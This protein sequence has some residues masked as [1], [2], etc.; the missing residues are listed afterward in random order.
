[1][2]TSKNKPLRFGLYGENDVLLPDFLHCEIMPYRS[3]MNNWVIKPH[4]HANL[5][6]LFLIEKAHI[7]Y[8]L[9]DGLHF[10]PAP[11][12]VSIPENNDH[13]LIVSPGI[14]GMVLTLSSS[15]VETIF[16]AAPA[17]LIELSK[18]H[19]FVKLRDHKFYAAIRRDMYALYDEIQEVLPQRR[20]I[21]QAQLALLLS[22]IFRLS[23]E[24]S[25]HTVAPKSIYTR[26]FNLFLRD[27]KKSST[28]MK[29]VREYADA[30]NITAVHLN[31]IC[32]A[33]VGKSPLD[34]IHEFLFLEAGK[35]LLHTE[36]SVSEVAYRLNFEDPAY[37]TRFF[38]KYAGMSPRAF[39]KKQ[40]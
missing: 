35:Y 6:Q 26:N 40:Q 1:M 34:I 22:R 33:T 28:P 17:G 23:I 30:L 37:F 15:F 7:T 39:R 29:S 31:R 16:Q 5:F 24:M 12:I 21:L 3:K 25:E 38:S 11:A 27:V 2:K 4:F 36:F 14:K 10:V 9:A 20:L 18:V 32:R 8:Q 19:L 13:G